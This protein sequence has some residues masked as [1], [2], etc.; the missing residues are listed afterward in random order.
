MR[1]VTVGRNDANQ[2]LD[3]FMTKLFP[4]MAQALMYKYLRK[5]AVRVNGKH[6]TDGSFKLSD[7]DVLSLYIKDEFFDVPAPEAAYKSVT[8]RLDIIYED[9][10]VLLVNKPAGLVVHD[11]ETKNPNTLIAQIQSYLYAKGEYVPENENTFAPA[12]CNRIDRNTQGIV[13]AAKNAETLRIL[14]QKI[15]DREL[16]KLYLCLAFGKF[17]R[18]SGVEQA[19]L[20][21]YEQKKQV[22]IFDAPRRGAKTIVTKYRVL[23]YKN[24]ISLVEVDLVTGRTHQIRAHLAHLGHPLVG[25]GKYGRNADNKRVGRTYQALCAYKLK[26]DFVTD[27]GILSYLDKKVFSVGNIDFIEKFGFNA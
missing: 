26:F 7:G 23:A 14:N 19:Y 24:G 18:K 21:R 1:T 16:S 5:K 27:A 9:E 3:K 20:V 10:N 2:R 6:V 25:D 11:D 8:A 22:A 15:K 17:E 4:T 12:L 13:I